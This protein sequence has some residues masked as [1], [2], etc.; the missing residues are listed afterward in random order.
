[1]KY[2]CFGYLD[3]ESWGKLPPSEQ[4]AMIDRCFAYDDVLRKNGHWAGGEG[5]QGATTLSYREGKVTVSDGPYAETK[6][7]LGGFLILEARDLN[8]AIQ[9]ISNHPGIRMGRWE[10]RAVEDMGPM[11]EESERRRAGGK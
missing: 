3:T 5:L 9:L 10:I 11:I 1:M 4:N 2:V 7:L 6:E 8:Q